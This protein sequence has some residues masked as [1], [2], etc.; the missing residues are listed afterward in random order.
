MGVRLSPTAQMTHQPKLLTVVGPTASGKS[1]LAVKLAQEFDGEIISADSRQVYR[2]LDI[3]TGKI[4]KEEMQNVPHHLLDV[5][6]PQ[7]QFS[8]ADFKQLADE[9][10]EEIHHRDHLPILA[11]GTGFYIQ[12]VV[13]DL[14]LPNVPPNPKLRE[15]LQEESTEDLFA[16]LQEKDPRRAREIDPDNPRR[17][18]RALEVVDE[19]GHVPELKKRQRYDTLQIGLK[20]PKE[21]LE[22]KIER[23]ADE[24]FAAGMIDEAR[25]L[26]ESG[27]SYERMHQ[28]GLEYRYLAQFLQNEISKDE[29]REKIIHGDLQYAKRQLTWFKKDERIEWFTPDK[30]EKIENRVR[31]WIT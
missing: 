12:A 13:D 23:R 14:L 17:L 28:L 10:V 19:L 18:I 4:T 24:Y 3:A 25:E 21:E 27:L 15:R 1:A 2:G 26:H 30:Y 7:E 11:G 16:K 5:A 31:S 22:R 8:V 29:L 9:A 6:D 20:P